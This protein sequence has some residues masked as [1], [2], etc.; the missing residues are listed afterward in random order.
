LER[1]PFRLGG[2]NRDAALPAKP[3]AGTP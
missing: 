3:V 2:P 1:R